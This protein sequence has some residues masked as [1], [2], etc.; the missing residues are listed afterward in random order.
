MASLNEFRSQFKERAED[1]ATAFQ[2]VSGGELRTQKQ[3]DEVNY[4][5]YEKLETWVLEQF[6]TW[7]MENPVKVPLE[8]KEN[9]EDTTVSLD[10]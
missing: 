7:I 3:K 4:K 5:A 1:Y 9:P 10:F 6:N 2:L 8:T